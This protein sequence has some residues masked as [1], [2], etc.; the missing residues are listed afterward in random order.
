[1]VKFWLEASRCDRIELAFQKNTP[2]SWQACSGNQPRGAF[3]RLFYI[4]VTARVTPLP[5][6]RASF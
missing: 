6:G 5:A 1:M 4:G 3:A 2:Y